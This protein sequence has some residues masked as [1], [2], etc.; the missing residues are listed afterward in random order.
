MMN[1]VVVVVRGGVVQNVYAANRT[2]LNVL[3]VDY[4]GQPP[5]VEDTPICPIHRLDADARNL[6]A[7]TGCTI[8]NEYDNV[9]IDRLYYDED[10]ETQWEVIPWEEAMI[11]FSGIYNCTPETIMHECIANAKQLGGTYRLSTPNAFYRFTIKEE[12][13]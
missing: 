12:E 9:F 8:R 6:I 5:Y 1:T 7:S 11:K 3:I 10:R 4:D 2:D 13:G